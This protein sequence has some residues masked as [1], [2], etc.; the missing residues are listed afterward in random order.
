MQTTHQAPLHAPGCAM[1]AFTSIPTSSALHAPQRRAALWAS[2]LLPAHLPQTLRVLPAQTS[3]PPMPTT[4]TYLPA[5]AFQTVL[6]SAMLGTFLTQCLAAPA[7]SALLATTPLPLASLSAQHVLLEHIQ[8]TLP[9]LS[10]QRAARGPT[11]R[12]LVLSP[13]LRALT[14]Y[15][16]AVN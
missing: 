9:P 6:G 16:L 1:L 10:A 5:Q 3:L 2:T 14:P 7:R 12:L 11:P 13:V 8:Q 15:V 4:L